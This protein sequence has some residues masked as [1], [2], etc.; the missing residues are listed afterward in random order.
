MK[1][2]QKR[3]YNLNNKEIKNG[4]IVYWMSRDQRTSDN[5]ALI[6]AKEL[7]EENNRDLSVVFFI[8]SQFLGATIRQYDFMIKGLKEVEDSLLKKNIPFHIFIG[9]PQEKGEQFL[10]K[11]R[12]GAL[13]TDFNPLKIKKNW[14]RFFIK[15]IDFPFYEVDAHNIVPCRFVSQ[16]QEFAAYTIRPK[17]NKLLDQF[18]TDFPKIKKQE[19]VSTEKVN[20]SKVYNSL[21]IDNSVK[22]ISWLVPG[23]RAGKRMISKFINNKLNNYS[24][25]RNNPNI[26]GQ[27]NL[28]P[29]IHFGQISTQRIALSV[30]NSKAE[31]KCKEEFLEELI[32]RKELSDN[33]CFY[34]KKY[35]SV[36]GFPNWAK[37]TL[38]KHKKDK[39]DYLYKLKDFERGETSDNLWNAAQREM[40]KKGKMH[41]YM[42][43]YWAKK[44]LE[45]TKSPKE[46]LKIAIYLNDKY[47]LDGRDSR[48]YTGIAWSVG[49]VHD[50]A[51]AEREVFGKVRYMSYNGSKSKFNVKDYIKS[52]L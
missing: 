44:I 6:F 3:V 15:N 4:S 49:G 34:N 50:R 5:W 19:Q 9:T 25:D 27:S 7:A 46:A 33:F 51:W 2:D 10:K 38:D 1:V 13:V 20:W 11:I 32:I 39:R 41:G 16:K 40:I 23:E 24:R 18:L 12:P 31:K 47:H 36:E 29:Y 22:Q 35:D 8:S 28:S 26:D 21:N 30:K 37:Q 42:R 52:N 45:W 17:I 48:G 43:M 14:N